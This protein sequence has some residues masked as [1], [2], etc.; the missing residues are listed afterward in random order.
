[1]V[2]IVHLRRRPLVDDL[3]GLL[4][5]GFHDIAVSG[6]LLDLSVGGTVVLSD[7]YDTIKFTVFATFFSLVVYKT[8]KWLRY[9]RSIS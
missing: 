2:L 9:Q 7:F 3:R 4:Y 5:T 6:S 8:C 1:M